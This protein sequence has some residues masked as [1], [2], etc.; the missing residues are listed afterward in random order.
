MMTACD[1]APAAGGW[2]GRSPGGGSNPRRLARR[3]R[4]VVGAGDCP[5]D[6]CTWPSTAARSRRL[7][8]L[9]SRRPRIVASTKTCDHQQPCH[10]SLLAIEHACY[11]NFYLSSLYI[12]IQYVDGLVKDDDDDDARNMPKQT[13]CNKTNTV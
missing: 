5:T 9:P 11:F 4:P 1:D 8:P 6:A 10:E 3:R 2:K 12:F 13:Q 7:P